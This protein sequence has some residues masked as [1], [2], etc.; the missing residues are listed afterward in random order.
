M[1][2]LLVVA[3]DAS[4]AVHWVDQRVDETDVTMAVASVDSKV[5]P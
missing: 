5:V 3:M 2:A 4:L 1:G